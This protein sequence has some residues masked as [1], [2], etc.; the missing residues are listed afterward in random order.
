MP[1][2]LL[3]GYYPTT[4]KWIPLQVD[5]DGY[6][7]VDMSAI[8]L[9]DLGDVR[10]PAPADNN[11]LYWDATAGEWTYRP[12]VEADIPAAIARDAEVDGKIVAYA[13]P[14]IHAPRHEWLG[15]DQVD[16]RG[17]WVNR[18]TLCIDWQ[19]IGQWTQVNGGSGSQ[20]I[21][22]AM[23]DLLT[24]ATNGSY[25]RILNTGNFIFRPRPA[26]DNPLAYYRYR[27]SNRNLVQ[28]ASTIWA[29]IFRNVTAPSDTAIHAAF[30]IIDGRIYASCAD[31]TTQTIT[32]TGNTTLATGAY[33]RVNLLIVATTTTLKYYIDEVLVATHTTHVP[34]SVLGRIIL[35]IENSAAVDQKIRVSL[36]KFAG[37]FI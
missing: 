17:L 18:N 2:S 33:G 27:L 29:G 19:T 32:D 14:L 28:S 37:G 24:G 15:D 6:V 8:S 10:V 12:L 3:W 25:A 26:A 23:C 16:V 22:I 36:L 7:K 11:F 4:K 1:G 9:G 5:A 21:D 13:A 31:G 35:H 20:V 30:K 34:N